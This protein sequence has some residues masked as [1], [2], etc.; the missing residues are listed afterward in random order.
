MLKYLVSFNSEKLQTC[1]HTYFTYNWIVCC[2]CNYSFFPCQVSHP[3]KVLANPTRAI[4]TINTIIQVALQK[5]LLLL[6]AYTTPHNR[7]VFACLHTFILEDVVCWL[8][9]ECGV[10]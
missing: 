3:N 2:S 4:L 1:Y 8:L 7:S 9:H 6:F 10:Q 5:S